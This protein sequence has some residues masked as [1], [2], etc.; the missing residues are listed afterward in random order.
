[1]FIRS[2][3]IDWKKIKEGSYL[4]DIPALSGLEELT[5]GSGVTLFVGE[6]GSGKTTLLEG[7]AVAAGFNPEGGTKNYAFSTYEETESFRVTEMFINDRDR[8]LKQLL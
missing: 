8:L 2:V 6:N 7:I 5:F 3:K 1:M 4:R